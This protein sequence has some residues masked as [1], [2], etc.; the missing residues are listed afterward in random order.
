MAG[1]SRE[2]DEKERW[3]GSFKFKAFLSLEF[4]FMNPSTWL[5]FSKAE[6]NPQKRMQ[7]R[8]HLLT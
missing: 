4:S 8:D 5:L 3:F 1:A 7:Y 2:Y 6:V